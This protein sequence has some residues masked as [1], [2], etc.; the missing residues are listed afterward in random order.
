MPKHKNIN[1]RK[2]RRRIV[3]FP[4]SVNATVVSVVEVA[5]HYPSTGVETSTNR[6]GAV[7]HPPQLTTAVVDHP[8]FQ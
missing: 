4:L 7:R 5:H 2:K 8:R 6:V 1:A 3:T